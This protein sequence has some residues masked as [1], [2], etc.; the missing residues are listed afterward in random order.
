M[1]TTEPNDGET[2]EGNVGRRRQPAP[3]SPS[4]EGTVFQMV[5]FK[6][7]QTSIYIYYM[8]KYTPTK[9]RIFYYNL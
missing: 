5:T 1:T 9:Y 4:A 6:E 3:N 8:A 2:S 7:S